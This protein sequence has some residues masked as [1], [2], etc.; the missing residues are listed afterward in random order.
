MCW[1]CLTRFFLLLGILLIRA[2]I[3]GF[4]DRGTAFG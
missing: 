2:N 4:L 3:G 1:F